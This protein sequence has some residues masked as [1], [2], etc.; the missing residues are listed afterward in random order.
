MYAAILTLS[1]TIALTIYAL[2]TKTDFTMK[3]GSLF[4]C[5]IA[6]M[7]MGLLM[8]LSGYSKPVYIFFCALVII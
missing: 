4:I 7:V 8:G 5:S 6:L 1:V 2:T 3:G